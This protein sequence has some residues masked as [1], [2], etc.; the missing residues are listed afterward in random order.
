MTSVELVGDH[1]FKTGE[2]ADTWKDKTAMWFTIKNPN[3]GGVTPME[4]FFRGRGHK[5]LAFIRGC[6]EG[7]RP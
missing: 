5:V 6:I 2:G 1:F 3:L 4:L 7:N